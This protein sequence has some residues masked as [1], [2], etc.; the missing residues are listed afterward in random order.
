MSGGN[1]VLSGCRRFEGKVAVVTGGASGIGEACVRRLAGE[2]AAVV[3]A[4]VDADRGPA[5]AAELGTKQTTFLRCD[6]A[7]I[8]DWHALREVVLDGWGR[9]DVL[10]SNAFMQIT[11]PAHNLDE[12]AWDRMLAVN[13]KAAFLG[14]K[15]LVDLLAASRGCIVLT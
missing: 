5:L 3:I 4:D 6:V 12:N 14:T 1:G 7:Q 8:G 13:L 15:V 9:L 2:G 10:H 11:A